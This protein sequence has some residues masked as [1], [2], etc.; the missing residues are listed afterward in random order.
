MVV[1]VIHVHKGPMAGPFDLDGRD[2]QLITAFLFPSGGHDDPGRLHAN[3]RGKSFLRSAT[4]SAWASLSMIPTRRGS[5]T[6]SRMRRADE[7][8][9]SGER[10]ISME[11][12]IEKDPRNQERIFPYIGGKEVNDSPTPGAS[13]ICD[14][15]WP[16]ERRG[17]E[18]MAGSY[19]DCRGASQAGAA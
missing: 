10:P 4:S 6:R 1:S 15:F 2:C 7:L 12:L 3:S 18:T 9:K 14:Q 11:E 8:A 19:E 13:S 16:D 5:P 17:G